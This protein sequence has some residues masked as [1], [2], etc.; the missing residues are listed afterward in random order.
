MM[1]VHRSGIS[2]RA[3]VLIILAAGSPLAAQEPEAVY[4]PAA[5]GFRIH[6]DYYR[7]QK[8]TSNAPMAI[9]LH[10]NRAD[11]GTWKPLAEPL[12]EAGFA[13]LAIDMRGHGESQ[14]PNTEDQV[15]R[16]D[17]RLYKDMYDDVRGAYDWLAE[18]EGVDRG[19]VALVG[20][21]VGASVAL[22][23]AV[24]DKSVDAIVCLTPGTLYL[25]LDSKRDTRRIRG[26]TILLMATQNERRACDE[27]ARLNDGA[28]TKSYKGHEAHGT[29]MFGEVP[30]V[31]KEIV[32]FL[33]R[34]VGKP[35]SDLC[36]GSINSDIYHLRGSHW[37]SRIKP[38]NLRYY[39]SAEEA[40]AR[41]LRVAKT[42]GPRK[43]TKRTP[44]E[45]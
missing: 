6:A 7:A 27:L 20:A 29:A 26:R 36:F 38:T 24:Q 22:R 3:T 1:S 39:S 18:Q 8:N 40:E 44:E 15:E 37:M 41:G 33:R 45:P 12:S 28:K 31:E 2:L 21:S 11:R 14:T 34:A 9:L 43:E 5:D 25:G 13:T 10:M 19:R 4:F 35:T 42:R 16:R 17:T 32:A 30:G 23:Y